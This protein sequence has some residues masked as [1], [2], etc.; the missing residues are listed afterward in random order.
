MPQQELRVAASDTRMMP[1]VAPINP[2]KTKAFPIPAW[3]EAGIVV[4]GLMTSLVAHAINLFNF[5]SYE[6]DEG[7]YMASAWAILHGTLTPYPYGYG[8]PP[9]G[10]VQ[11][12]AWVQLTGGFF[13]FG[14]AINSGRVLMLLY[15]VAGSLLVYLIIRRLEGSRSAA[16]LAMVIFSLSPLSLIYQR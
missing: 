14:N 9:L 3:L 1:R 13:T 12:A 7:T 5:P 6:L 2:V 11:I 4:I 8:H 10:W 16:L 15:A